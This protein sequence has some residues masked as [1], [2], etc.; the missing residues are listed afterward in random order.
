MLGL[1]ISL[2]PRVYRNYAVSFA[3]TKSLDLD[4]TGDLLDPQ[5]SNADFQTIHRGSHTI[6]MWVKASWNASFSFCGFNDTG[7]NLAGTLE[8]KYIYM[9]GSVDA[10][11]VSGKFSNSAWASCLLIN[12]AA[13]DDADAW[14]HLCISQTKGAGN[15]DA[16]T[17]SLYINGSAGF[18]G[19]TPNKIYQE[20]SLVRSGKDFLFGAQTTNGSAGGNMTGKIDEIAIWNTG[21]DADAVAA[22]YNSGVPTDLTIDAGN[23]DNSS[24]LQHYYRLEDDATDTQGNSD[25]ALSGDPAY[26][27]D[28]PE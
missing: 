14:V 18:T 13:T 9:N 27:T 23:Y 22:V 1:G 17:Y 24:D 8:M 3:N 20:A 28:I 26:S 7:S 15:N 11:Q 4:G 25:G 21:L 6:S 16:G 2:S 12:N 19:A 5:I 10:L